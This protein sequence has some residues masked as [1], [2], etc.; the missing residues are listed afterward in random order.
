MRRSPG[1][2]ARARRSATASAPAMSWRQSAPSR[3]RRRWTASCAASRT[4]ACRSTRARRSS[5]STR[6]ASTPESSASARARGGSRRA[7]CTRSRRAPAAAERWAMRVAIAT[8]AGHPEPD[9]ENRL[10]LDALRACGADASAVPWN[11]PADWD[12]Y[13]AVVVRSTWDY[14]WKLDAFLRW[15]TAIGR[16]LHNAPGVI[17]WN[18]DKRY[19]FDLERAGI[20]VI[21]G[22]HV[23][24]GASF[25]PPGGRFVVKPAV[26]AGARDTAVYD[27]ARHDAAREH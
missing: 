6:A 17:A 20:A 2:C 18:V 26:S 4:M 15:A 11:E 9:A 24:A 13:D 23:A 1:S 19:L 10:L 3:W 5:R 12:A 14:T 22:E 8:C 7:S 27:G 16:R 25:R 21:A